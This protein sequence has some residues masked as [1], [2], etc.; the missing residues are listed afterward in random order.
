MAVGV[1]HHPERFETADR[2][3]GL[4]AQL[5][6]GRFLP[7]LAGL[8]LPARELPQPSQEAPGRP[9]LEEPATFGIGQDD[10]DPPD[11]GSP[12]PR[13]SAWKGGGIVQFP[14]GPAAKGHGAPAAV[15]A[16]RLADGLTELHDRLVERAAGRGSPRVVQHLLE[17]FAYCAG[18]NV[19]GF[20]GPACGDP[21]AVRLERDHGC[22]ES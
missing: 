18:A 19:P 4:F 10:H 22:V 13:R 3:P 6:P 8:D 17:A 15:R 7:A 12:A 11:P 1:P 21:E 2:H 9:P 16:L 5:S 14:M 20:S